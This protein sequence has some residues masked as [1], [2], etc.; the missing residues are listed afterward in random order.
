MQVSLIVA[1]AANRVI[2][3]DGRL[4]WHLPADLAHFKRTTMGRPIVMGRRTWDSIGRPLPGRRNIVVSRD[5]A[6][7]APGAE[8]AGSL[9]DAI[10]RCDDQPEVFVIGGAQVYALAL[11][12][13]DRIVATEIDRAYDGDAWFPALDAEAWRAVAREAH[14]A[15]DGMPSYAIVEYRRHAG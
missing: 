10:A 9:D 5:L 2:G 7:R 3:R 15:G 8:A 12:R 11:P 4:P 13:A 1:Y 6:W 14:P